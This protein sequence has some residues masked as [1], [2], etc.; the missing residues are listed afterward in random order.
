MK[1]TIKYK[2]QIK[3]ETGIAYEVIELP[4]NETLQVVLKNLAKKH[5]KGFMNMLFDDNNNFK[6][7][8]FLAINNTQTLYSENVKLKDADVL[9]IMSPIAG[10]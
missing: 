9:T 3:K 6:N 8:I 10:G 2:S 7:T 4:D 1:I 5:D